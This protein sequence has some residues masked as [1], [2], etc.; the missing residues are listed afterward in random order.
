MRGGGLEIRLLFH[1]HPLLDLV[2]LLAHEFEDG[3]DV[4]FHE[5]AEAVLEWARRVISEG[6]L[7]DDV[8]REGRATLSTGKASAIWSMKQTNRLFRLPLCI[9]DDL[10]ISG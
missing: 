3:R 4:L 9:G 8:L 2:V 6:V 5:L 1:L 7:I 10:P